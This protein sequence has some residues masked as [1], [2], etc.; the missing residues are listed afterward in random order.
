MARYRK[1]EIAMWGDGAFRSL[2]APQPNAQ[3]LWAWFLTGPCTSAIPGVVVALEGTI[4]A[5]LRWPIE[6]FR[7]CW[8]E[9]ENAGLAR[10][11]WSAGLVVLEKALVD[12]SGTPRLTNKPHNTN[13]LRGWAGHYAELPDC[14]L[15][16]LVLTR[17]SVM[18]E[19]LKKSYGKA[20]RESFA[21]HLAKHSVNHSGNHS[22]NDS[23]NDT[24]IRNRIEEQEEAASTSVDAPA[25]DL[26]GDPQTAKRNPGREIAR[27]VCEALNAA[28]GSTF[29]PS[30]AIT[31]DLADKVAKKR[32][33]AEDA[34]LVAQSK[35]DDWID[36][37]DM[38]GRL[39]PA[40]LL[41]AANFFKYLDEARSR[42]STAPQR[43]TLPEV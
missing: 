6:S 7:K 5:E 25:P 2:S 40:T 17:I 14:D 1:T 41:R 12:A 4:A 16:W 3:T 29:D 10:A 23:A 30:A 22:A 28:T 32:G 15:K 8:I 43:T 18:A 13:V 31:R 19:G 42:P 38:R 39:V 20:F 11:D 33:T 34:A 21:H 36:S 37:A 35:I 24:R 27:V 9:I 26:F